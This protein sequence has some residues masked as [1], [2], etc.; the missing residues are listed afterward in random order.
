MCVQLDLLNIPHNWLLK[1][2]FL[3]VLCLSRS[4]WNFSCYVRVEWLLL[5]ITPRFVF[6]WSSGGKDE[7]GNNLFR[8]KGL[9]ATEG[10]LTFTH[11]ASHCTFK[12]SLEA[13]TNTV[14]YPLHANLLCRPCCCGETV[15][16]DRNSQHFCWFAWSAAASLHRDKHTQTHAMLTLIAIAEQ[17]VAWATTSHS[18]SI[19]TAR[20]PFSKVEIST[21][22]SLITHIS[23]V[24]VT[25]VVRLIE[26]PA[27]KKKRRREESIVPLQVPQ[28]KFSSYRL[29]ISAG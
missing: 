14:A 1:I 13:S 21:W 20:N 3:A 17:F 10:R 27:K 8:I 6:N 15:A 7:P 9:S 28:I 22:I 26:I 29:E 2:I 24:H 19:I 23:P 4:T 5:I 18:L 25:T 16:K 11:L 12:M